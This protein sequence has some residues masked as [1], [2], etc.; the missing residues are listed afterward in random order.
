MLYQIDPSGG[1][2]QA[3]FFSQVECRKRRREKE[4]ELWPR[5]DE[6][7]KYEKKK[8][9]CKRPRTIELD[10]VYKKSKLRCVRQ[11]SYVRQSQLE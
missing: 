11:S 9:S 6:D 2:S 5:L 1:T 4:R 8:E 10:G 7:G 3:Q